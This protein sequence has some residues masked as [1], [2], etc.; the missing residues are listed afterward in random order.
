VILGFII[1][2]MAFIALGALSDFDKL[3]GLPAGRRLVPIVALIF[4]LI[5]LAWGT[6]LV[7]WRPWA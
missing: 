7:I 4:D 5:L 3:L 1:C 6:A 2:V